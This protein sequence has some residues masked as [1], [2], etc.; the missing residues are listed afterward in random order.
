MRVNEI[1]LEDALDDILE[2]EAA[3]PA[4]FTLIDILEAL[5]NRAHDNHSV[6]RVRADSLINL[7]QIQQPQFTLDTL[8]Q[9]RSENKN[10][11]E[12]IKDIKDVSVTSSPDDSGQVVLGKDQGTQ[13]VKYVYLKPFADEESD[14][15]LE[16]DMASKTPPE[17]TVDSMAKSALA[18]RS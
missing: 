14:D 16:G 4:V 8:L 7:I 6:P 2:D 1:I 3:D 13:I 15:E 12:L 18:K 5:R 17:R 9:L 11:K 10:V